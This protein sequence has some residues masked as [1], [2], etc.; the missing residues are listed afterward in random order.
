MNCL[1]RIETHTFKDYNLVVWCYGS[2]EKLKPFDLNFIILAKQWR[3]YNDKT[4]L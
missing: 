4:L 3:L 1:N 2:K